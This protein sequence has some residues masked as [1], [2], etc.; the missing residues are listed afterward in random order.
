MRSVVLAAGFVVLWSSGF[1][2]ARLT[3]D[4]S[5][6]SGMLA[7]R[8]LV[9]ALVLLVA[10]GPRLRGLSARDVAQQAVLGLLA[11]VVFLGG[12]FG[13]VGAGVDAG[14]TALVAALQPMLVATAGRIFWA[15]RITGRQII[16]LG[17]GLVAVGLTVGGADSRAGIAVLIPLCSVVALS[18]A[19]LLE[20]RWRP[21]VDVMG[22]LTIQVV[23]SAGVFTAYATAAGTLTQ[24]TPTP[25]FLV[26]LSGWSCSPAWAATPPSSCACAD[27]GRRRRAPCCTSRRRSRLSGPGPCSATSPRPCS[28]AVSSWA[29][30]LSRSPYR[31]LRVPLV[32]DPHDRLAEGLALAPSRPAPG[33][34]PRGRTSPR[35]AA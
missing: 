10:V 29:R 25:Q 7:W 17:L 27:G 30:S 15:D 16:G 11:H 12:V 13:A 14:T 1:V 31:D 6:P 21:T 19:A 8:Y 4:V 35:S 2:G 20:R 26:A 18:G 9:T 32:A 24:V 34:T 28:S 33:R 23:V 22:G 3:A 5:T